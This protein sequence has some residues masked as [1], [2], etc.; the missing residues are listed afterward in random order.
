MN[1]EFNGDRSMRL[2]L[3]AKALFV[4]ILLNFGTFLHAQTLNDYYDTSKSAEPNQ[5]ICGMVGRADPQARCFVVLNYSRTLTPA[6]DP[7]KKLKRGSMSPRQGEFDRVEIRELM[8]ETDA[9]LAARGETKQAARMV[10]VKMFWEGTAGREHAGYRDVV[11]GDMAFNKAGGLEFKLIEIP[12]QMS[13]I[14]FLFP[15]KQTAQIFGGDSNSPEVKKN[16]MDWTQAVLNSVL[17]EYF[18][19]SQQGP[20]RP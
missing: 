9:S 1:P 11:I 20:A 4:L 8:V 6:N 18:K 5:V 12:T 19:G 15:Q 16:L 7:S 17:P 3:T 13:A 14:G 2:K 10:L